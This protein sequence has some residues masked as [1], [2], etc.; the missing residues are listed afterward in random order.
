MAPYAYWAGAVD[1]CYKV[2]F[3]SFYNFVYN[4]VEFLWLELVKST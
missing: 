4:F 1:E 2:S 3:P